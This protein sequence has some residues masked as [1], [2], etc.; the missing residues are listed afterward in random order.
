MDIVVQNIDNIVNIIRNVGD[1]NFIIAC[2]GPTRRYLIARFEIASA[3]NGGDN[4]WLTMYVKVFV[5]CEESVVI[6]SN[7][8]LKSDSETSE[9]V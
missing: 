3:K 5:V 4:F 8:D 2:Q 7:W 1:K 9:Y 6:I